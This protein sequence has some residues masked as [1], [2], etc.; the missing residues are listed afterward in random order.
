MNEQIAVTVKVCE[1]IGVEE[2]QMVSY[3]K[4]F[5]KTESIY[6]IEVWIKKHSKN[7]GIADALIS[8]LE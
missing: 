6:D 5:N 3:T 4:V 1:Q 7:C 2:Y 8:H